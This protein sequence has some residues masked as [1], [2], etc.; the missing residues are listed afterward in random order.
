MFDV[1]NGFAFAFALP[2][3]PFMYRPTCRSAPVQGAGN[4]QPSS[5]LNRQ[6]GLLFGFEQ[7]LGE[8]LSVHVQ[9]QRVHGIRA[10]DRAHAGAHA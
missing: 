7:V 4:E 1:S 10:L 3:E 9:A 2:L 5:R 6:P 8:H